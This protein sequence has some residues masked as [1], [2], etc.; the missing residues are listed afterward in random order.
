[1][2]DLDPDFLQK[3]NKGDIIV[4]GRN[5][6]CGSSREQ[7]AMCLKYIGVGAVVAKSFAR[8]FYRNAINQGLFVFESTDAVEAINNGDKLLI[9]ID[10]EQIK[11]VT[12]NKSFSYQSNPE[13]L[14]EIINAGGLI[15]WLHGKTNK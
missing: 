4:A 12:N 6:G 1:M 5:F 13:F 3:F 8:I 14:K 15:P 9:D 10:K 7:A 2:E 11:N